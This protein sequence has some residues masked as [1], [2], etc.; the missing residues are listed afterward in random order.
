MQ[1]L[2]L[3]IFHCG[4]IPFKKHCHF[5]KGEG[6]WKIPGVWV[7]FFFLLA[8]DVASATG[9]NT[10]SVWQHNNIFFQCFYKQ[11][12]LTMNKNFRPLYLQTYSHLK[13]ISSVNLELVKI[14]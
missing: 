1:S 4:R 14:L 7:G 11:R 13:S 2:S 3:A 12:C 8:W 10:S 9:D 5:C 6:K